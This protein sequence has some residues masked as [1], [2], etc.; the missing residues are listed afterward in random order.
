M[1]IVYFSQT[2]TTRA[3][4]QTIAKLT[5]AELVELKPAKA[6]PADYQTL[7]IVS[8]RE[9]D[10]DIEPELAPMKVDFAKD[11]TVFVGFPMWYHQAP[12]IIA[13]LFS[14]FD[15]SGKKIVPFVTSMSSDIAEAMPFM[16]G[17]AGNALQ[18][19]LTANSTNAIRN[20]LSQ[21]SYIK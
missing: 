4:A 19:G 6:Y 13:S 20:Y 15:F 18:A 10:D 3:A 1:K 11:D 9:I 16:K 14:T 17:L 8:K 21:Y 2:G 12:M 5:G 7:T